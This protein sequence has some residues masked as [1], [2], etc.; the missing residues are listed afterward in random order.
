MPVHTT[1]DSLCPGANDLFTPLEAY[2][3]ALVSPDLQA[4]IAAA[5]GALT[6]LDNDK[7]EKDL[8]KRRV[9]A[10]VAF[11]KGAESHGFREWRAKDYEE[12]LQSRAQQAAALAETAEGAA[13]AAAEN[14]AGEAAESLRRGAA[15]ASPERLGG[16][17][18][19]D[20]DRSESSDEASPSGDDEA[21]AQGDNDS[22]QQTPGSGGPSSR[23]RYRHG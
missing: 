14:A 23:K 16:S 20:G 21:D 11:S 3:R 5:H 18:G 8:R 22:E 7:K 9:A 1:L 15:S 6:I 2:M 4:V 19:A 10:Y 12:E 17:G 13:R